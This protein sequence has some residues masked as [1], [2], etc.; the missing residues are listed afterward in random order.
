MPYS[1]EVSDARSQLLPVNW[2]PG[3][4]CG[5]IL[6]LSV[7]LVVAGILCATVWAC[8]QGRGDGPL[9]F[10]EPEK[11]GVAALVPTMCKTFSSSSAPIGVLVTVD[12]SPYAVV[13]DTG[14]S[15]FNLA[16]SSC[17]LK[18]DVSPKWKSNGAERL[19][20]TYVVK[21]GSG[22][23]EMTMATAKISLGNLELPRGVF[24]AIVNQS[25]GV[26]GFNLFPPASDTN[27]HN[28]YAGILGLAYQGQDA[29]PDST[30]KLTTNGTTPTL[31]D[32]LVATGMPNAFA[33]E[34]CHRYPQPCGPRTNLETW[35]P[36]RSCDLNYT[37]G[38]LYLGGYRS[39][40]LQSEMQYTPISDEIHYNVELLGIEVCGLR[41]CLNVSFPD[42][43]GGKT[44]DACVCNTPDCAIPLDQDEYCYFTVLDL[45]A[46]GIFMNTVGNTKAL[47][48]AMLSVEMVSFP[49]EQNSS[50]VIESFYFKQTAVLGA[51]VASQSKF[52][53]FFAGLRGTPI[54][55]HLMLG[56]FFRET[57][58]GLV[59]AAVF[60]NL[61]VAAAFQA[62]K[63]PVLLGSNVF[64]GKVIFFDRS[65]RRVG[66]ADVN[67][68]AC[69]MPMKD[70]TEI[71][72]RGLTGV[73]TPG[74]GCRKGT[75]SGGGCPQTFKT[76]HERRHPQNPSLKF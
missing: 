60:G 46:D 23:A 27:C 76:G 63:F 30:G 39:S 20:P 42:R 26:D 5:K 66:F 48:E 45:G 75:G 13:T 15:N 17:E 70:A 71:D 51:S 35:A 41:G 12:G 61:Q 50:T 19:G 34:L 18:C 52:Q 11:V 64:S 68:D 59:Q 21:Y 54:S 47:L 55:H 40:S 58:A 31:L 25:A 72:V 7:C 62:S 1:I 8:S 10:L 69:G 16:S 65:R 37:I 53:L 32:Q 44:E 36:S 28:T 4:R 57:T 14:S 38:N 29:G 22:S 73:Q 2:K 49:L 3:F 6:G 33:V 56:A 43:I 74:V 67:P 24:S 9:T